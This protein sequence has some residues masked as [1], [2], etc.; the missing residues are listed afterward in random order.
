[1]SKE[2]SSSVKIDGLEVINDMST[3]G[4]LNL[5]N[6]YL[7]LGES[8]ENFSSSQ[9]KLPPNSYCGTSENKGNFSR[10]LYNINT[11]GPILFGNTQDDAKIIVNKYSNIVVNNPVL[12]TLP[13]LYPVS[14]NWT[15]E[16]QVALDSSKKF[17]IYKCLGK[18]L[19]DVEFYKVSSAI[20]GQEEK[21][22][23]T[24]LYEDKGIT[25][26]TRQ[27]IYRETLYPFNG[28]IYA[29]NLVEIITEKTPK[30]TIE[31]RIIPFQTGRGIPLYCKNYEPVENTPLTNFPP[32][33][34]LKWSSGRTISPS[35]APGVEPG[36]SSKCVGIV[37]DTYT[38][39]IPNRRLFNYPQPENFSKEQL[40]EDPHDPWYN[41]PAPHTVPAVSVKNTLNAKGT[42]QQGFLSP[43]PNLSGT[44]W[45]PW[46]DYYAY[47]SGEPVPVLTK[48]ITTARIGAC[49]NIA[50]TSYGLKNQISATDD[51]WVAVS[52]LPLFQGEK[53]ESGSYIYSAVKGMIVTP[54][55][56]IPY[57]RVEPEASD[58]S[59]TLDDSAKGPL[60]Q[61]PW[62][63]FVDS[64]WGNIGWTGTPGLSF[65]NIPDSETQIAEILKDSEGNFKNISGINQANQG[66]IIVHAMSFLQPSPAL[67]NAY[68][69]RNEGSNSNNII[70]N[71]SEE[72][73][74]NIRKERFKIEG[75]SGRCMLPQPSPEKCQPIGIILENIEG[76]G[77]WIYDNLTLTFD[78]IPFLKIQT[79]EGGVSYLDQTDPPTVV[80]TRT[81]GAFGMTVQW[82]NS[83]PDYPF[84]GTILDV[85]IIV[86]PGTLYS[87]KDLI[88]IQDKSKPF[89]SVQY[90][91][92]NASYVFIEATNTLL[93][94]SF[95]TGYAP[96]TKKNGYTL[97]MS[98]NNAYIYF[99]VNLDQTLSNGT[100]VLSSTEY[101]QDYSKYPIGTT[102]SVIG[103][104]N[105]N[106]FSPDPTQT[107]EAIFRVDS[108]TDTAKDLTLLYEGE[109]YKEVAGSE[110]LYETRNVSWNQRDPVVFIENGNFVIDGFIYD[111]TTANVQILDYGAGNKEGDLLLLT[112]G[113]AN[114][115]FPFPGIPKGYQEITHA[116]SYYYDDIFTTV[117]A[118][119][120]IDDG[121]TVR[122][123]TDPLNT[124]SAI[125]GIVEQ[126]SPVITSGKGQAYEVIV[127]PPPGSLNVPSPQYSGSH[128]SVFFDR[129]TNYRGALSGG[130]GYKL[131]ANIECYNLTANSLRLRYS[132]EDNRVTIQPPDLDPYDSRYDFF[133]SRYTY[134]IENGTELKLLSDDSNIETLVRLVDFD[135]INRKVTCEIIENDGFY[136]LSDGTWFF[137][138]QRTDQENPKVDVTYIHDDLD[139]T[140]GEFPTGN[141]ARVVLTDPGKN[142]K[143][144][145]LILVKSGDFNCVFI[146]NDNRQSINL[147]PYASSTVKK[148][149]VDDSKEAW[150]EY[151]NIM[152]GAVNL[153]DK[154]VLIELRPSA[155]NN[156]EN[157]YP[158]AQAGWIDMPGTQNAYQTFY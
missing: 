123:I 92:N 22:G 8:H 42:T 30:G 109:N 137:Q 56:D 19:G 133:D 29:G 102:L 114:G 78:N 152:S 153:L 154:E 144:G 96:T 124:G 39:D 118:G 136:N 7:F 49:Y 146:Y 128:F 58:I 17:P 151:S 55:P 66:S 24:T 13:W 119:T 100:S 2:F 110:Y 68:L 106:N 98:K 156:T 140:I 27:S 113:D 16:T 9:D 127:P 90:K 73:K 51:S 63:L 64:T 60:G 54:G 67:G 104:P 12:S 70:D 48:G 80:D 125:V 20:D 62:D 76:K 44:Y 81:G 148:Y 135:E 86:D 47:K 139:I 99:N 45:A 37:L 157:V 145:D 40:L 28:K 36:D 11:N 91:S 105:T 134:D 85:P 10:D 52:T 33:G 75:V 71:L 65:S 23:T 69:Q 138:T 18:G 111:F 121:I 141:V 26:G 116:S 103:D 25:Y 3:S 132:I 158:V 108:F 129:N 94:I 88:V 61:T 84:L 112:Q 72:E 4:T 101:P 46:P 57:F 6:G 147:P 82:N 77:K 120:N 115:I 122:V 34:E 74:Y 50:L 95:G 5:S 117:R 35:L 1:M 87:D 79:T 43:G 53:I 107:K 31:T 38:G 130:S 89:A 143:E 41:H 32:F 21:T 83:N 155:S 142:N 126:G 131:E 14:E 59:T 15:A 93:P 97:N 150:E 149:K